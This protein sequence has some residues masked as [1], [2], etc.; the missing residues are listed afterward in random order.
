MIQNSIKNINIIV[1]FIF[2]QGALLHPY[3]NIIIVENIE[4]LKHQ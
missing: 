3:I 1:C 2:N 4:L